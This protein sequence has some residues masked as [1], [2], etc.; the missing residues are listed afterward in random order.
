MGKN[1]QYTAES[2]ESLTPLEFTRL[3][4]GVYCGS[5]EYS[6]QLIVELFSNALDEHNL[7]HGNVIKIDIDKNNVITVQD[8]G[9]GFLVNEYREDGKTVFEAALSILNTSGKY[10]DDG[11]YEGTS[12]GLN[13]IG[14]KLPNFLSHWLV[15]KTWRDGKS[16]EVSFKEG[17]FKERKVEKYSGKDSGTIVRFQ[18]SEDFFRHPEPDVKYLRQMFNGICCLCPDLIVVLNGEKINHPGLSWFL[19]QKIESMKALSITNQLLFQEKQNKYKIDCGVQYCSASSSEIIAYVNYGLT[20]A[21][22][23]ITTIKS[24][25]TRVLNKWA[26]EQGLLKEKEKNL[27]GTSL[28]EGLVLVFNLVAPGISYDAQ[29]KSRIVSND[30][31][32]FLND[33]VS[34]QLEIWL[35]NNPNDGKNIIEKA[36]TARAAA[37]AAKKARKAVKEKAAKKEKVFKLPTTLTDC[38]SKNRAECELLVCEGKS[39]ASGLVAARDGKFQAVYGVRGKMISALKTTPEKLLANQEV[40]NLVQ[41]LG[42]ECDQKTAKLKYD[43]SKLRYGKIIA[44]ADAD[45][46]GKLI[47]N[48]L[49]NILWFMCPE[50]ITNGHVYSAVPPLYRITTRK[51]EYIYLRGDEELAE[52]K[53]TNSNKTYQITRNKG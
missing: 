46:D 28:Q 29:T 34:K 4:P 53:K 25:I 42:L 12:L 5:T 7:G 47:E 19:D 45:P 26:K 41:A 37:E 52:Y 36:L 23:H 33:V 13:G 14:M 16:E 40:N 27:D 22:P 11:V 32:S 24:C 35:D 50:L 18:P 51:N 44:C 48:L 21:G 31:V 8:E 30:F 20:D 43:K 39:A 38:W 9:Q 17:V 2:I 49:F 15:A 3:R 6:T 10:R 1:S